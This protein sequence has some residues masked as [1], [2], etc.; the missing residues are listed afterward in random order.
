[1]NETP[2]AR[3]DFLRATIIWVVLSIVG[4]AIVFLLAPN[5]AA[6]G[7]LP[8]VASGLADDINKVLL[9]FTY[10]SVP[11]FV[12]VV[13]Y[14]GY[15]LIRFRTRGRP[16]SDGPKVRSHR[17]LQETWIAVTL[18]LVTFLWVYG[19]YFLN[20]A[21]AAPTGNVLHVQV[22]GEQWLWDY[23]YPQ[24][25]NLAGTTLV[26][27]VNRPVE[28]DITSIDVQHSFWIPAL[29]I[30]EDAV[31]GEVTHQHVTPT[32]IGN[33]AVR[34]AELCGIY[35][36][37]MNTPVQVVSAYDFESWASEQHGS[38]A[39]GPVAVAGPLRAVARPSRAAFP[40][41]IVWRAFIGR[42]G[43]GQEG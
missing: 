39:A 15:S 34:C 2:R 18:I 3:G 22:T 6:L 7:A 12:M 17:L 5:W 38:R 33:Y 20:Q 8:P 40:D 27:P 31:P 16:T 30:K 21:N 24:Y 1:M 11:V 26:L 10:L 13:V 19:V 37:Y 4:D 29:G 23:H 32:V 41:A 25:G 35:H 9:V 42:D 14:G 36:A 43:A 28:F